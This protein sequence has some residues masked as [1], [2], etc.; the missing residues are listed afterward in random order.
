[1]TDRQTDRTSTWQYSALPLAVAHVNYK[2]AGRCVADFSLF[3]G[4]AQNVKHTP[5]S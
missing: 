3:T 1:M 4:T 5:A 2:Q